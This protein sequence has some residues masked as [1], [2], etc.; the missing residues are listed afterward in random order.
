[1]ELS[2]QKPF[3]DT[4]VQL[5]VMNTLIKAI[6]AKD[7]YTAGHV[8]RVSQYAKMIAEK[9]GW[10]KQKVASIEAG[11]MMHDLGKIG[12]G[13]AILQKDGKLSDKEFQEIRKH[14]AIGVHLIESSA[15]LSQYINS[16]L[17]HHERYDGRGYPE[18]LA[19]K[20]I[21]IEGRIIAVADTFDA[22]TSHRPYRKALDTV[23]AIRIIK[24]QSG[25]QFDPK[26]VE[27]FISL[28]WKSHF[29]EIILHSAP[30]IPLVK[31][32]EHGEI[33]ERSMHAKPGDQAYC[34]ACKKSFQLEEQEGNW[35]VVMN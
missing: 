14:P 20:E 15:F 5:E 27:I 28:W 29:L 35:I 23:E 2:V 11:A 17:S 24:E 32:P 26:I 30:G 4:Q 25:T 8:W 31:C 22:L 7:P 19:G 33:I 1:M 6:E 18:G 10:D 16:V 34:A 21:P 9:L 13:D 12:V 3:S